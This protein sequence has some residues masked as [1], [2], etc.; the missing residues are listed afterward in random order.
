MA[1]R[2]PIV[3]SKLYAA[4]SERAQRTPSALND[5]ARDRASNVAQWSHGSP[6]TWRH[7]HW[8]RRA[9][10]RNVH[11]HPRSRPAS[12]HPAP[13]ARGASPRWRCYHVKRMKF[14]NPAIHP[15]KAEKIKCRRKL[16]P[17]PEKANPS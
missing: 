2:M 10:V 7:Y 8:R 15:M 3:R 5:H 9:Y 4:L 14:L 6:G 11:P 12:G 1:L 16:L 17:Y 13:A